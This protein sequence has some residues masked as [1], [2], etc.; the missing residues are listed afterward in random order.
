MKT[1]MADCRT[2][3]M[4]KLKISR[5]VAINGRHQT[6]P[7]TESLSWCVMVL[8]R[9]RRRSLS[10][11]GKLAATT[12]S[13]SWRS[14][15]H[16]STATYVTSLVEKNPRCYSSFN[17]AASVEKPSHLACLRASQWTSAYTAEQAFSHKS[18]YSL[19]QKK[20]QSRL[21]LLSKILWH[22]CNHSM[23]LQL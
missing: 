18:R 3:P 19:Q 11:G 8:W 20:T 5:D 7:I 1:Y 2:Y 23:F 15:K 14:E 16:S 17:T 9:C 13:T 21:K 10:H 12:P 6:L 4:T 22:H